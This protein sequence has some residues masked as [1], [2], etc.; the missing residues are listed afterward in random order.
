MIKNKKDELLQPKDKVPTRCAISQLDGQKSRLS[1]LICSINFLRWL[2]L[3]VVHL[4]EK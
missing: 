3:F 2:F 1:E 4:F